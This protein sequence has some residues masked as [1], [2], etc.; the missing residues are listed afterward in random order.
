VSV[1][2]AVV[3][4]PSFDLVFEGLPRLPTVG[5]EI[6]G[7]A[8]HVAPG[9]TAIQA[10]GMTRLGLS[11]ALVSPRGTD[12]GGRFLREIL[13]D[14]GVSWTGADAPATPTTA[15]LSMHQGAAMATAAADAEPTAGDVADIGAS[16]VVLS[17]GRAHLRPAATPACFVSGIVE[18]ERGVSVP[19]PSGHEESI[20]VNTDEARALT[21]EHDPESAAGALAA[22]G[23]TAIVTMSTDGA[24]AVR[25]DRLVRAAAPIAH[26][27]DA[28]GAGDLFI[29]AFM[30]T[31]LRGIELEAALSWAC[32]YAALSIPH[33]TAWA[34]ARRLDELLREGRAH[35]LTPP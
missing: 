31:R 24:V 11:A 26:E 15:V 33:P 20:V 28:T 4:S 3:G 2:V 35:G 10:I 27:G 12:M 1:D 29:A 18:I 14:E 25:D 32:L 13:E 6:V 21:G 16:S 17:L 8:F 7:R 22:D 19:G 23:R 30:W 9:S 34:G 5:E